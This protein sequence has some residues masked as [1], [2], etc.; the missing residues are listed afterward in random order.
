MTNLGLRAMNKSTLVIKNKLINQ[1]LINL[2]LMYLKIYR[3]KMF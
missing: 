3:T 1:L 2:N